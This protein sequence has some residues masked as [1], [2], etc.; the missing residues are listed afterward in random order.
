MDH[1]TT[2]PP[3]NSRPHE[4]RL[5]EA[6][7]SLL[8]ATLDSVTTDQLLH[9]VLALLAEGAGAEFAAVSTCDGHRVCWPATENVLDCDPNAL[10]A[11]LEAELAMTARDESQPAFDVLTIARGTG[12]ESNERTGLQFYRWLLPATGAPVAAVCLG[13][14]S[15]GGLSDADGQLLTALTPKASRAVLRQIERERL[16]RGLRARDEVITTVAHELRNPVN[17]IALSA[18][19]LLQRAADATTRRS[20]ER[21][22]HGAQRADRLIQ[23]LLDLNA[24]EKG[25]FSIDVQSVDIAELVLSALALQQTLAAAGSIILASDLAPELPHVRGDQERIL[26]V[27][28]NLIGNAIKFTVPGDTITIGASTEDGAV[29]LWVRDTGCGIPAEHLPRL[30]D[31]F[32]QGNAADRRGTGL[33]LAIC[34]AIVDAHGGRV[35]AESRVGEG[36]CIYFTLPAERRLRPRSTEIAKILIVDDRPENLLA[37]RAILEHPEY[38][39]TTAS[40]GEQALH[41]ALQERFAVALI[42]VKMPDISGIEVALLMKQVERTRDIPIIFVTAFGKDPEEIHRAY[43]AGC[44]DYLVKPLDPEVVRKKVA[45]FA[46]LSRSRQSRNAAAK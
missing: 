7:D 43:D 17:V 13:I 29:M 1:V 2:S 28:E 22:I 33:G 41:L 3:G 25:R 23:D 39:V 16:E 26:E 24:I 32:W 30:F 5:R 9:A 10:W 36:T 38:A 20:V 37:L 42:D 6:L 27:I 46:E 4:D 45:F 35:W 34:K 18:N 11:A 15:D 21:I 44:V 8:A 31:R 14:G 19:Y 12:G 40:S